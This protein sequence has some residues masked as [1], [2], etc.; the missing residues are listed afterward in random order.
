MTEPVSAAL[1]A[2]VR[3]RRQAARI[4]A[5]AL[6]EAMTKAGYPIS[7]E[8]ISN[9][10][11]GRVGSVSV[12]FLAASARALGTTGIALLAAFLEPCPTCAGRPPV[13]FTCNTCG[14]A[15]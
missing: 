5:R 3:N 4:S 7:R 9:Q 10:E 6:A 11:S 1:I 15:L 13:G 8:V 12:D 2:E 14:A